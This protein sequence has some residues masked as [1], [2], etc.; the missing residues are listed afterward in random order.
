MIRKKTKDNKWDKSR[1]SDCNIKLTAENRTARY[2]RCKQCEKIRYREVGLK[3][4]RKLVEQFTQ[5]PN[6]RP[7]DDFNGKYMVSNIGEVYSVTETSVRKLRPGINKSGYYLVCLFDR[8][9]KSMKSVHRLVAL[10]FIENKYPYVKTIINHIDGNKLNNRVENLEWCNYK[11]NT[12]HALRTGLQPRGE[13]IASAKLDE[14]KVLFIYQQRGR[15]TQKELGEMF[16]VSTRLISLVQ[17][18]KVWKHVKR[19]K[20]KPIKKSLNKRKKNV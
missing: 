15:L 19:K 8:G 4:K 7:V 10:A 2:I 20:G 16:G 17:N 1:C 5:N 3:K 14:E 11:Q 12:A 13:Q 9:K 6:V 18:K